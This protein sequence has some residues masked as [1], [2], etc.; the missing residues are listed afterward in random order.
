[1][2][3]G[4]TSGRPSNPSLAASSRSTGQAR[5]AR[6]WPP[7]P[8]RGPGGRSGRW[9][10][11]SKDPRPAIARGDN[12]EEA[13]VVRGARAWTSVILVNLG[14]TFYHFHRVVPSFISS[15]FTAEFRLSAADMGVFASGFY[16]TY[17]ALQV[18]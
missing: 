1:L 8:E 15:D 13:P 9:T 14:M 16:L 2:S 5:S 10:S 18:P 11:R 6:I 7:S 4:D 12:R 3:R 17:A